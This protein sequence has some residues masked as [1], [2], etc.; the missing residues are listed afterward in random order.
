MSEPDRSPLLCVFVDYDNLL[1]MQHAAGVLS[2]ITK[3]LVQLPPASVPDKAKYD[4]RIYGGW[5]E[6]AEM[7]VR[8]QDIA[9]EIQRDFP[10]IIRVPATP[11][12]TR[13]VFANAELAVS[14]MQEP[15]HHL[16]RLLGGQ[17][18]AAHS[19]LRQ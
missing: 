2:L 17:L 6:A 16:H 3:A 9:V 1:P 10:T 4:V 19:D 5:Y 12:E 11:G 13:A 7:T 14:L 15:G 8:A 18:S